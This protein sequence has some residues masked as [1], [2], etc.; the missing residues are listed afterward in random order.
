MAPTV[1]GF[2]SETFRLSDLRSPAAS[3]FLSDPVASPCR[4]NGT[5][6][7]REIFPGGHADGGDP[8]RHGREP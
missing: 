5:R 4:R 8:R 1:S 3:D 6:S 2:D 7:G